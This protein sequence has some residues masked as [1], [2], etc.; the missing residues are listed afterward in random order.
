ME[1]ETIALAALR[2]VDGVGAVE[3]RM[4]VSNQTET[5]PP[6]HNR[7][8]ECSPHRMDRPTPPN[9][10][11]AAPGQQRNRKQENKPK[12]TKDHVPRQH[13]PKDPI[14]RAVIRPHGKTMVGKKSAESRHRLG[15]LQ[16]FPTP[17]GRSPVRI[18][19][20]ATIPN[21]TAH[22]IRHN[23]TSINLP[24]HLT[25]R[26]GVSHRMGSPIAPRPKEDNEG[27]ET[28]GN[29]ERR[30]LQ[31]A[32]HVRSIDD[33]TRPEMRRRISISEG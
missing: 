31:G 7:Q 17:A 11:A 15:H 2:E 28:A 19:L 9:K 24:L 22:Q 21:V 25:P 10:A 26:E 14:Q 4:S 23:E 13:R 33:D 8:S 5:N 6:H 29:D 16:P 12:R 27:D 3:P 1:F 30:N 20:K 18:P 32:F